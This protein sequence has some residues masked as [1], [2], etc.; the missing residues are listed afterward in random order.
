MKI[1]NPL[2]F[3]TMVAVS[4]SLVIGGSSLKADS[5]EILKKDHKK[6]YRVGSQMEVSKILELKAF[7]GRTVKSITVTYNMVRSELEADWIY[8]GKVVAHSKLPKG[9]GQKVSYGYNQQ[10]PADIR[11]KF[12]G[13]SGQV[14]V[15]SIEAVVAASEALSLD[16]A[17]VD[18]YNQKISLILID[19]SIKKEKD[20]RL[21]QK[22]RRTL[23][24]SSDIRL[25][26]KEDMLK[27]QVS[28]GKVKI[29]GRLTNE[30]AS[31]IR[32]KIMSFQEVRSVDFS[33]L[34]IY[35]YS[36]RPDLSVE[37]ISV[38][39]S[40]PEIYQNVRVQVRIK[41]KGNSRVHAEG[42][43]V[44]ARPQS[45]QEVLGGY[46]EAII[47]G[48]LFVEPGETVTQTFEPPYYSIQ[49]KEPGTKSL[50]FVADDG[51]KFPESDETNNSF[52]K[53]IEVRGE[54]PDM[55]VEDIIIEPP[56][57]FVDMMVVI[58]V[59]LKN[60]GGTR[61]HAEGKLI[62]DRPETTN[63]NLSGYGRAICGGGLYIQPGETV[64]QVFEPPLYEIRFRRPGEKNIVFIADMD[65]KYPE[66]DESNN[67]LVKI[68]Q[69]RER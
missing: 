6:F 51:N 49:W 16:I 12:T 17:Q 67:R 34:P 15:I 65:D 10:L 3:L 56:Q 7:S 8:K 57:P 19:L 68:I 45:E 36:A 58:K 14:Q 20:L 11:I 22:I 52:T 1:K 39:P 30:D 38:E 44:Y 13:T 43:L 35:V 41:N 62:Y 42:K 64:T 9:M 27:I 26:K 5:E 40:N 48:G 47:G 63:E 55:M 50:T 60:L 69:V 66:K 4:A 24:S 32:K 28:T 18:I 23:A 54:L 31:K 53:E 2:H 61:I 37:D 46:G 59:K 25:A 33:Q 21:A 29:S